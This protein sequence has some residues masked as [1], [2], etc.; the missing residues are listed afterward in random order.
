MELFHCNLKLSDRNSIWG[1]VFILH[2]ETWDVTIETCNFLDI[3]C[4][5]TLCSDIPYAIVYALCDK[6]S[7]DVRY[8]IMYI[9]FW[10]WQLNRWFHFLSSVLRL[11]WIELYILH[12]VSL[13]SFGRFGGLFFLGSTQVCFELGGWSSPVDTS[14]L[15]IQSYLLGYLTLGLAT[16]AKPNHSVC[17][18]MYM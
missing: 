18:C 14:E 7:Y 13:V 10:F 3:N 2:S 16:C 5:L 8:S 4:T 15:I 6:L 11:I 1:I 12:T 17:V 9:W